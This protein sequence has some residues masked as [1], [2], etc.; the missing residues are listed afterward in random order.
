MRRRSRARTPPDC[1]CAASSTSRP[2]PARSADLGDLGLLEQR[3][4]EADLRQHA[5]RRRRARSPS[6]ATR[7]RLVCHGTGG[8]ASPSSSATEAQLPPRPCPRAPRACPRR[9]RAATAS[10]AW[11]IWRSR[12]ARRRR[13]RRAS[14]RP[15]RRT[16]S[17]PP[18]AAASAPAIG[19][20]AMRLVRARAQAR[21][22]V[23]EARVEHVPERIARRRA[24]P[25]CP[26]TSW[27]VA[28]RSAP[29]VRCLAADDAPAASSPA[30]RRERPSPVHRARARPGRRAPRGTRSAIAAAASVGTTP[31]RRLGRAR[32]PARTSSIAVEPG[33]HPT[34]PRAGRP[35][36][37]CASNGHRSKNAVWSSPCSLTSNRRPSPSAA[38]TSVAR[39]AAGTVASTSS[40]RIRLLLVREVHLRQHLGLSSPRAHTITPQHAVSGGRHGPLGSDGARTSRWLC[41]AARSD[42]I[43]SRCRYPPGRR[44]PARSPPSRW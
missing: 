41:V 40:R 21:G 11:R 5:R 29:S 20:P 12:V 9:R 26:S 10:R 24:S 13:A 32:A 7:T 33:A 28:P 22:G 34:P 35:G 15:W 31:A 43:R 2:C 1:A 36:R 30:A 42:R 3:H 44:P 16:S 39:S 18:A 38:A 6:S 27:L 19:R 4:V 23:V 25:R 17:A 37:R 8:S 14:P